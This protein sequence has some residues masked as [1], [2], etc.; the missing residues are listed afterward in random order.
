[1]DGENALIDV[2]TDILYA[3]D[4]QLDEIWK[5]MKSIKGMKVMDSHEHFIYI[6]HHGLI[7][8][9]NYRNQWEDD[10]RRLIENGLNWKKVISRLDQYNLI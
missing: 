5:T 7:Q 3:S 10:I 2:H 9:A 1:M 6:M 8:H 4:G